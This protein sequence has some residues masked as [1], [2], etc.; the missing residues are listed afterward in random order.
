Q[1]H[2]VVRASKFYSGATEGKFLSTLYDDVKTLYDAFR[3][4]TKESNNGRCLGWRQNISRPYQWIHYNQALLRSRNFGSGLLGLGVNPGSFVGIYSQ[5]CPE[6]IITEQGAYC[7]SMVIVALY[8]TLGPDA[9]AFIINQAEI[10]VLIVDD[11]SKCNQIIDRAP[12]C[13]KKIIS[14]KE[15]R[16]ATMQRARSRAIEIIRFDEIERAGAQKMFEEV[17]PKSTD[18]CTICYTSGTT[19]N[20]K[21]VM[22]THGNVI[23]AI[24]ASLLQLADHRPRYSDVLISFLPLAHMLER[25]CESA[26]LLVGGSIG[27]YSGD[28]KNL[29]DDMKTLKP[30]IMPA[31]PR[32]LNRIYDQVMAQIRPSFIKRLMFNMAMS[33]KENE[34]KK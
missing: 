4:G 1:G 2:D 3:K 30:T 7:Y 31:V 12:R 10:S 33:A 27:Y 8:D 19:G 23:A 13:L 26:M 18:L 14:I 17:A 24:S 20:P 15:V 11:D 25:T 9:C 32:L 29:T 21:G 16:M 28:I 6:W 34:I 22:L 5:N